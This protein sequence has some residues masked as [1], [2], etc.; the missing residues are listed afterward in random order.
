MIT[1]ARLSL[2][3]LLSCTPLIG[4]GAVDMGLPAE[5]DLELDS[6]EW[7]TDVCSYETTDLATE[8]GGGSSVI[9]GFTFKNIYGETFAS[10]EG[11]EFIRIQIERIAGAPAPD[12]AAPVE[13]VMSGPGM[14]T[15]TMDLMDACDLAFY[16]P[17]AS[18]NAVVW[19]ASSHLAI[20]VGAANLTRLKVRITLKLWKENV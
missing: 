3:P 10:P 18:I 9:T 16:L 11:A 1:T 19:T 13:V 5:Y 14:P 4:T 8:L 6:A 17:R 2:A 12:P 7:L 15:F 20:T